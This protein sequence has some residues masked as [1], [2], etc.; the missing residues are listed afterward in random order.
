[1]KSVT[2][3]ELR[4]NLDTYVELAKNGDVAI[5]CYGRVVAKLVGGSETVDATEEQSEHSKSETSAD[6]ATA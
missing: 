1:M 5:T 4:R 3:T 6:Q 2:M